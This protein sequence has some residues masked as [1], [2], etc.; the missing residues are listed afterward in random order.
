MQHVYLGILAVFGSI[1]LFS[2]ALFTE[3]Y[4][5]SSVDRANTLANE[6][7]RFVVGD[8]FAIV[9]GGFSYDDSARV[10]GVALP[11]TVR[12]PMP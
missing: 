5:R 10:F 6:A 7:S 11:E 2:L 4:T 3:F 9:N 1:V 8:S 12:N